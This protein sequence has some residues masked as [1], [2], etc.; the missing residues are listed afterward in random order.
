[1]GGADLGVGCGTPVHLAQLTPGEAVLDLGCGA[2]I[3]CLLA[4]EDVGPTGSVVGKGWLALFTSTLFGYIIE[5]CVT[6]C[7]T[8]AV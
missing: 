6:V 2:G 4:A 5:R 1:V 7:L 8:V 3:D